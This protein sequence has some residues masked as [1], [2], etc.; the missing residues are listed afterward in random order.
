M[1]YLFEIWDDLSVRNVECF[2]KSTHAF[3]DAWYRSYAHTEQNGSTYTSIIYQ[4]VENMEIASCR[5]FSMLI[6]NK[7]VRRI[8]GIVYQLE[9]MEIVGRGVDFAFA[10]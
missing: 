4:L 3:L 9:N 8:R 5:L 10:Y 1:I 7:T 6:L 2:D